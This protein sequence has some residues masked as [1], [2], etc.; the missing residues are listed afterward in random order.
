[1]VGKEKQPDGI[2]LSPQRV[3][4]VIIISYVTIHS[5]SSHKEFRFI[6][7]ILP[8]ICILSSFSMLKY[9]TSNFKHKATT[10]TTNKPFSRRKLF[11][12]GFILIL[13]NFPHQLFLSRIHQHA[14]IAVNQVITSYI[15]ELN[16]HNEQRNYTIHYMMGCHSTPLYSHLHVPKDNHDE[17]TSIHA[18]TL[19]CSPQCRVDSSCESDEFHKEPYQFMKNAYN[20]GTKP[21]SSFNRE[22]GDG[23][24]NYNDK[25][26]RASHR[27]WQDQQLPDFLAI[28]GNELEKEGV[29]DLIESELDMIE[30]GI[31]PHEIREVDFI[32]LNVSFHHMFLYGR[33]EDSD[34]INQSNNRM[35]TNK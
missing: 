23:V 6:M 30:V 12:L 17:I 21:L 18:W 15:H 1:M 4:L 20:I 3:L 11:Q 33:K 22:V 8:L 10:E 2:T 26:C 25:S 35:M 27:T 13:L 34:I 24:C 31:F 7:P 5:I 28:F 32:H 16:S 9:I 29:R 14:P 19:D